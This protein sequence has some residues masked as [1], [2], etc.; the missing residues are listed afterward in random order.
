M[1][2]EPRWYQH[3]LI[4]KTRVA[5]DEGH[6]NVLVVSP[7]RS[8]KTKTAVWLSEPFLKRGEHV[9]FQV[10]REELLHQ[11]AMEYAEFGY[12][13]NVIAPPEVIALII[14]KQIKEFGRSFVDP[15]AC[16]T[17]GSV[18]T[19]VSR[20]DKLK[21]WANRVK[22][23]ITDEAHHLID[24][25]QWGKV[26]KMLTNA[27]GIGFTA[28]PGRTDRKSMARVQG[29][30][31]DVMV[32]GVTARQ[33]IDEGF[34]CDYRIIAP[35]S[36]IDRESIKVG[37]KGDFTQ[38][39]VS[40]STKKS[41][42][43]GDCVKSYLQYCKGQQA[44]LFAV[45]IEH[46]TELSKAFTKAGVDNNMITGK[47]PRSIRTSLMTKFKNR[48][49]PLLINVD[50]FGE[51]LNIEGIEVVI[52]A[53][54]TKSFVLFVQ[55]FFRALTKSDD[56]S[57]IGTIVDHA[58]NV[59][60]FGKFYGMPDTY[61]EW[62]LIGDERG[63]RGTRDPNVVPVTV[64]TICFNDYEA[65]TPKCPHCGHRP[66]PESRGGPE[67]VDGDLIELDVATLRWMRGE[68][69]VVDAPLPIDKPKN[70][71][72][73][74][75]NKNHRLRQEAQTELRAAIALWAG[76]LRDKGKPDSEIYRR[77]WHMFGTD[78]MTAQTLNPKAANE[79]KDRIDD[80]QHS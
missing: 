16:M 36:S 76:V 19:I 4:N 65:I 10:H 51:G 22:L 28:T 31:F 63:K 27:L 30:V 5:W 50:L 12:S 55:Q 39:S 29:G 75:M 38:K 68:I 24:E 79:L 46:A 15:K 20:M 41:S 33:L 48:S 21:Q 32:K 59:G 56:A 57:K 72:E 23:W 77:F 35:P 52:M 42:I 54:P 73:G 1:I 9:L 7:P 13:H 69:A 62:S 49:F 25:S 74:A 71:V 37:G 64:C 67:Y 17:I 34:I 18:Q 43:T 3:D 70:V 6:K 60:H 2:F 40:E 80:Q 14:Q 44:V 53:R 26:V 8:G 47:T 61:N 66:E 58:G 78:I 45:D 11:V